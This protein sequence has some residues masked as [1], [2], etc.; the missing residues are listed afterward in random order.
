MSHEENEENIAFRLKK[1]RH[2]RDR[3]AL[4]KHFRNFLE[5]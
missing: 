1:V 3:K 4:F 5:E 2:I